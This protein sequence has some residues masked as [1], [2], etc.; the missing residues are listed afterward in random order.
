MS[1][2][3]CKSREA[4]RE[5]PIRVRGTIINVVGRERSE[6][7]PSRL[8]DPSPAAPLAS[9]S[10]CAGSVT[11]TSAAPAIEVRNSNEGVPLLRA[12]ASGS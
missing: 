2:Y 11:P 4:E 9:P 5:S 6:L 7:V 10:R 8:G 1:D 3:L 12:V